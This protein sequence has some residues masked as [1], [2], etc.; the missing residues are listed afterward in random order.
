[1]NI[2]QSNNV[3]SILK[4]FSVLLNALRVENPS[5]PAPGQSNVFRFNANVQ[6]FGES[7]RMND[8]TLKVIFSKR[9]VNVQVLNKSA[10]KNMDQFKRRYFYMLLKYHIFAKRLINFLIRSANIVL[11]HCDG[12][13]LSQTL[14]SQL[15]CGTTF[16]QVFHFTKK[17]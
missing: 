8:W 16:V 4:I 15:S 5:Y 17:E 7:N 6:I 10:S 2:V 1:M 9:I 14:P 3:V 12:S 11:R 13:R